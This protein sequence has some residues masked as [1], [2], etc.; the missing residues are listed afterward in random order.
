VTEGLF[1]ALDLD[2]E[3]S[4]LE[5]HTRPHPVKTA[6]VWQVRE[7]LHARSSRR[8]RNYEVQLKHARGDFTDGQED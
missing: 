8:W 3:D 5:F 4:V 1:T 7:A 6:S 2:W